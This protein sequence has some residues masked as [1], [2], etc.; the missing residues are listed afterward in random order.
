MRTIGGVALPGLAL[1]VYD[2]DRGLIA[3]AVLCEE[4]YV[5]EREL[6]VKLM[7]DMEPSELWIADR[8]FATTM[9][10]L[11]THANHCRFLVRRHAVNGKIRETGDWQFQVRGETGDIDERPAVIEDDFGSSLPVRL[12]RVRLDTPKRDKD[13]EIE[14]ITDLP[15]TLS[16][17]AIAHAIASSAR[18][19]GHRPVAV[20]VDSR[21]P[22]SSYS[23][24]CL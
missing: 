20:S 19:G 15:E 14:L 12:V 2:A 16:A 24:N 7:E 23:Q 5:Q 9:F 8:N 3:R 22:K 21:R 11:Q 4:A 1:V 17:L 13:R 10:L 18:R 6:L